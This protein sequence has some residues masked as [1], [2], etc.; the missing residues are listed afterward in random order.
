MKRNA[1]SLLAAALLSGCASPYM[2]DRGNDFADIMTM[3]LG[4][5]LGASVHAGPAHV[6]LF[7][8]LDHVGL[9]GGV[10]RSKWR[11]DSSLGWAGLFDPLIAFPGGEGIDT[12]GEW[13]RAPF[14]GAEIAEE[15]GKCF[16]VA[17]VAPFIMLP[18]RTTQADSYAT[19]YFTQVEASLGLGLTLR[20]GLNPGELLDF[21]LGWTAIDIYEDDLKT[22]KMPV[23]SN[24]KTGASAPQSV[25]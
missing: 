12:G 14:D 5:G 2:T 9:R 11:Q 16:E 8:G 22:R 21:I 23:T 17:G 10:F 1:I 7:G 18:K 20:M 19:H 24:Q 13:C 4:K 6:G 3:T 25:R 15:R